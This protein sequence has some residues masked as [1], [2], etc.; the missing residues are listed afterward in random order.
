MSELDDVRRA[1]EERF[2]RSKAFLRDLVQ[3][4]SVLGDEEPAQ[5]LV[6][7]RMREIG[8]AV[9]SVTPDAE[10]LAGVAESGVPPLSYDGRRCLIG[11]LPGDGDGV[12]VLNGHVDVVSAEPHEHWTDPPFTAVE[13]DGRMYGR[14]TADMKG[15]VAAMLL[16][17][18][19]ARSLGPL[20]ATVV[21]HS[22]IEEE[23]TGN[24]AITTALDSQR[25]DVALIAEPSCGAVSLAGVGVIFA[26]ITIRGES[27]HALASDGFANPLDGAYRV[28]EALR[29]LEQTLNEEA[30]DP[31][32]AA[33]DRPYLLN[34][35]A[36]H[37]GDWW[38]TS[39]GKA[40]LDVRL[41]FPRAVAPDE[42]RR[43]LEDAVRRVV[44]DAEV[45][46][47][48]HR[49]HGYALDAEA[50]FIGLLR[51]CHEELHGE[52]PVVDAVRATTDLRFFES[53]FPVSGGACYGPTGERYHG[54]DE[55]VD[56]ASIADVATV[57]G[58][59]LRRWPAA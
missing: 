55:W 1:V 56:L 51:A 11:E 17:V 57:I 21:Y 44:P 18:E 15:G 10:R 45:A 47:R 20:P 9:R 40:E 8:F 49:A 58:L 13:R 14:G 48:G 41:G 5:V 36:L 16:A 34:V 43:R 25:A 29:A 19:A 4:P 42:A 22:V 31:V 2:D 39:P 38:A 33:F 23:C 24:G 3:A 53:P 54:T 50:P 37:S 32:F 6:E 30:D 7:R 52:A 26:R 46:L 12:L 27:G 28:I 35:G 59:V